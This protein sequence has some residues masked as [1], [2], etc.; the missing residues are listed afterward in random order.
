MSART[1]SGPAI[2]ICGVTTPEAVDAVNAIEADMVGLNFFPKSPRYVTPQQA[3]D[4]A[5]GLTSSVQSVALVVNAHD[6][7]LDTIVAG[8][9]PNIIQVHG[10]ETPERVAQIKARF[11]LP[12]IKALPVETAGDIEKAR[13][14]EDA[15]DWLL[16]DAK[17]PKSLDN[18]LPGGNGLVFDWRLLTGF[19]SHCP[20][21]LSGGLDADN[22]AEAIRISG[23]RAV[24]VSSGVES[25]PGLKDPQRIK[26]FAA[27]VRS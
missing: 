12:V 4:L 19:T 22:V 2:K 8:A 15:A 27:A 9:A 7:E 20:W 25:Q 26:D 1:R 10:S 21:M 24:D 3:C 18:A 6:D 14:Y 23:A 17:P 16:F 13:L 5:A 11:G